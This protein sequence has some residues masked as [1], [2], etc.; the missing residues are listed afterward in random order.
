L[1][2]FQDIITVSKDNINGYCGVATVSIH[3]FKDIQAR[4]SAFYARQGSPDFDNKKL[5]QGIM[6]KILTS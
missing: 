3:F 5:S 1:V 2:D 6:E 4:F